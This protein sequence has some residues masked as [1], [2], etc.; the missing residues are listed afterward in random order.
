MLRE[1]HLI[2]IDNWNKNFMSYSRV[3]FSFVIMASFEI[4]SV[5][6]T[7]LMLRDSYHNRQTPK[8]EGHSW[9]AG[10]FSIFA[11]NLHIWRHSFPSATRGDTS[12]R[13]HRNPRIFGPMK[14]QNRKRRRLHSEEIH[15]LCRSLNIV[16]TFK[17]HVSCTDENI[18]V[19]IILITNF[20]TVVPLTSCVFFPVGLSSLTRHFQQVL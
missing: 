4:P 13:G 19:G 6:N 12:F 9:L 15:S 17:N 14:D 7:I 1:K 5:K 18:S 20:S 16:S 3:K 11:A 2:N 8:L 10:K